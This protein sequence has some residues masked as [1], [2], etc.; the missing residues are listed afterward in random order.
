MTSRILTDALHGRTLSSA[1]LAAAIVFLGIPRECPAD[2]YSAFGAPEAEAVSPSEVFFHPLK[3][4]SYTESWFFLAKLDQG[5]ILYATVFIT[6]MGLSKFS[7]GVE[8]SLFTPD[9]RRLAV[10]KEYTNSDVHA[11][12][13]AY[14]VRVGKNAVGGGHPAYSLHLEE[15]D[16]VID[17]SFRSLHPMWRMGDGTIY[18][19][20]GRKK[21]W[22]FVVPCPGGTV[23][24]RIEA[25]GKKIDVT[26]SGYHDHSLLTIPASSFSKEWH[27]IH[28]FGKNMTVNILDMVTSGKYG[29]RS[30]GFAAAFYHDGSHRETR[31]YTVSPEDPVR[32]A[33]YGYAYPMRIDFRISGPGCFMKGRLRGKK[34]LEKMDILSNLHPVSR[35][36]VKTFIANPVYYRVLSEFEIDGDSGGRITTLSGEAVYEIVFLAR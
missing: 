11:L 34:L 14:S 7:P 27:N 31:S 8:F 30:L 10:K 2:G 12:T 26:G 36:F 9:G 5:Y 35:A 33:E 19:G 23:S 3:D 20:E 6:N 24:G 29:G 16:V 13:D 15:N 32:D 28:I 22:R 17:L 25:E 21:Y 4:F 18:F 1:A